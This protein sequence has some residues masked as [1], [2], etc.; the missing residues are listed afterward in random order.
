MELFDYLELRPRQERILYSAIMVNAVTSPNVIISLLT[1]LSEKGLPIVFLWIGCSKS[2]LPI[3][4]RRTSQ[5]KQKKH[6]EHPKTG[7]A[8]ERLASESL[9]LDKQ[10]VV[11]A[12]LI[13]DRL[14]GRFCSHMS[15]PGTM[16]ASTAIALDV[17][18][19]SRYVRNQSYGHDNRSRM[20]TQEAIQMEK[21]MCLTVVLRMVVICHNCYCRYKITEDKCLFIIDSVFKLFCVAS[22]LSEIFIGLT[23]R[24]PRRLF[25]EG[26]AVETS[27][28]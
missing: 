23:C 18:I 26:W 10:T 7:R 27:G 21:V 11:R 15:A 3:K 14:S 13:Y 1:A 8:E 22:L 4:T 19:K 24:P 28:Q 17:I 2:G 5:N 25:E 12:L 9:F 16:R 6:E 20:R